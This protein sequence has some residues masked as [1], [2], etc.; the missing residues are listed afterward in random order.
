MIYLTDEEKAL[1]RRHIREREMLAAQG[2][3]GSAIGSGM[4]PGPGPQGGPA[5]GLPPLPGSMVPPAGGF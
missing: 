4:P 2:V 5:G 1:V 3:G